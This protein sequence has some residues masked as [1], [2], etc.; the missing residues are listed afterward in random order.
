MNNFL[1]RTL[2]ETDPMISAAIDDEMQRD[3]CFCKGVCDR[4]GL[5]LA[6]LKMKCSD[7]FSKSFTDLRCRAE[8]EKS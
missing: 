7:S 1:S 8:N 2:A 3:V 6:Y 4:I 5:L